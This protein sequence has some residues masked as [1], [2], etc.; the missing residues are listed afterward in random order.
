MRTSRKFSVSLFKELWRTV[1]DGWFMNHRWWS[2]MTLTAMIKWTPN[3]VTVKYESVN[4]VSSSKKMLKNFLKY[5]CASG[6]SFQFQLAIPTR[7]FVM[8]AVV[9]NGEWKKF[10]GKQDFKLL[11]LKVK[12]QKSNAW[13]VL[14]EITLHW[15]VFSI[16]LPVPDYSCSHTTTEESTSL[17]SFT[18]FIALYS[19]FFTKDSLVKI[20]FHIAVCWLG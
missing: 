12:S 3:D 2:E 15:R 16:I 13:K 9:A 17:R 18:M 4:Y 5:G 8:I 7:N 20:H 1:S 19:S 11:S 14:A 6:R 10:T